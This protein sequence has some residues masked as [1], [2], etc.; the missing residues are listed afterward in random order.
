MTVDWAFIQSHYD[1]LGHIVEG[2]GIALVVVLLA[3]LLF[4]WRIAAVAALAF[5]I[6]HFHGR[7]KRDYEIS[8]DMPPPH[9]EAHF[10]WRWSFDQMTDFWPVALVLLAVMIV[11][12]RPLL[13]SGSRATAPR[14]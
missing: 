1:W 8:V 6:G 12:A 10:L 3:R 5:A 11:I 14:R 9:L 7:E 2:V 4:P 13:G